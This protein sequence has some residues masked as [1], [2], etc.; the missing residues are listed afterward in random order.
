MAGAQEVPA[1][2]VDHLDL[3]AVDR[4]RVLFGDAVDDV[5]ILLAEHWRHDG[6]H[7]R[8]D[9]ADDDAFDIG[10]HDEGAGG[11]ARAAGHDQHRLGLLVDQC[12]DVTQHAQQPQV[13]LHGRGLDLAGAVEVPHTFPA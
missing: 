2:V 11:D 12:R 1:I 6:R 10:V 7:K 13:G 4:V 3:L 9:V 8:L 5:V